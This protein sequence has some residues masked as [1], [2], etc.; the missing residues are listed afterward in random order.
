MTLSTYNPRVI[1]PHA[2]LVNPIEFGVQ[3]LVNSHVKVYADDTLLNIGTHYTLSDIGDPDGFAVTLVNPAA[4]A[5]ANW[6]VFIDPPVEQG[7]DLSV[8]GTFGTLY[9]AALDA[10]VRSLRS[11]RNYAVRSITLAPSAAD[12]ERLSYRRLTASEYAALDE[13]DPNTLYFIGD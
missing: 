10:I 7:S 13:P 11:V 4:I 6:V 3:V 8:G 1:V 5:P 2:G 9:E 12:S